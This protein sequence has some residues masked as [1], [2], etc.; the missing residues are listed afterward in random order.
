VRYI[1]L[2]AILVAAV[3]IGCGEHKPIQKTVIENYPTYND[4]EGYSV[5]TRLLAK[6]GE[7]WRNTIIRISALTTQE[8]SN[9]TTS[10]E[11]C[12]KVPE[13]FIEAATNFREITMH[14]YVL[15]DRFDSDARFQLVDLPGT[16]SPESSH[17]AKSRKNVEEMI[18][19]G[20]YFVSPVGFDKPKTHA[21]VRIN[22]ICGGT[23]GGGEYHLLE[24]SA[25]GWKEV[26][27]KSSCFWQY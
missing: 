21:I 19:G 3:F 24:K 9:S 6:E 18:S 20:T 11:K 2:F 1:V 16:N 5:L 14:P 15:R 4:P 17:S 26:V 23:C 25:D 7:G 13:E 10:F 12:I 8:N 22:Y 27:P